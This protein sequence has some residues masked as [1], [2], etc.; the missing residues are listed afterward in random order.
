MIGRDCI[1]DFS[2][3]QILFV[4]TTCGIGKLPKSFKFCILNHWPSQGLRYVYYLW[5]SFLAEYIIYNI[6]ISQF[7]F[8]QNWMADKEEVQLV[9]MVLRIRNKLAE[10]IGI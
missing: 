5:K 7:F 6:L 2:K 4:G 1:D 9:D 8:L 10:A 3:V